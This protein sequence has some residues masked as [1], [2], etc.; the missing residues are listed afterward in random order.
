MRCWMLA[1]LL[2]LSSAAVR[3]DD[4]DKP[5]AV[6]EA[7]Y[8]TWSKLRMANAV[9]EAWKLY[10]GTPE[11]QSK[12]AADR[13][14]A[15]AAAGWSSE[16]VNQIGQLLEQ[17]RVSVAPDADPEAAKELNPITAATA[18]AHL[19]E[20][21]KYPSEL[22]E[23]HVR[24]EREKGAAGTP[25]SKSKLTGSWLVDLDATIDLMATGLGAEAKSGIKAKIAGKLKGTKYVFGPG[26]A[27]ESDSGG[28]VEK[29]TYRLD[30]G[31][32]L[33]KREGSK[34]ERAMQIGLNGG[35]LVLGSGM[36]KM[37]FRKQ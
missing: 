5:P 34:R 6:T 19:D 28:Q 20:I 4:D 23:A 36:A 9:V 26:D 29:G 31:T 30:G 14:Q 21:R 7:D 37:A 22:A 35:I 32:L 27:I 8:A 17:A 15:L 13:D 16:K 25:P 3:A 10:R 18:R 33:V 12:A 2:L 24:E 1:G 11:Q